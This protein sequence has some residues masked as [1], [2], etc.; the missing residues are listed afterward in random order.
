MSYIADTFN[1]KEENT[2]GKRYNL[3]NA[4]LFYLV[5]KLFLMENILSGFSDNNCGQN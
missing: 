1:I 3:R 5:L 2:N 4:D